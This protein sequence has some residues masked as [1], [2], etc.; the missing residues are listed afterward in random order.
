VADVAGFVTTMTIRQ[1]LRA[2]KTRLRELCVEVEID[3]P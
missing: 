1:I 2:E 3:Q